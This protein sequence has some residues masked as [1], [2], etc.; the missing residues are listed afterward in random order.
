VGRNDSEAHA[1]H[2]GALVLRVTPAV[3]VPMLFLGATLG[4]V[5]AVIRMSR[6]SEARRTE[7]MRAVA[8]RLGWTYRA[9]VAFDT[10]PDL[11]RFELFTQGRGRKLTNVM[12]SPGGDP[13][14]VLFD[15]AYVTGGGNSQA[16]H[17]QTVL[18]AVGDTLRLPKF[19][20]RPQRFFHA[21][22][23]AFGYQ[24]IDLER[25]AAFS[26]MFLLRGEDVDAVR[27]AF[28]D[29]A[30]AFFERHEG[31]CAA[32]AGRELLFWKPG[33]RVADMDVERFVQEG[34]DAARLFSASA[35]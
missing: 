16:T 11:D 7:E 22:A 33:K 10:I 13:R 3:V 35:D 21:L 30:V 12:T 14:A 18:Y 8:E 9:E 5:V 23:K 19:S 28:G 29:P 15:Y 2:G 32:G 34:L 20:L 17:R 24:D 1:A 4:A 25:H 31:V 26:G 6:R 27:T